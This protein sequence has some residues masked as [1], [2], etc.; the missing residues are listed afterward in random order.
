MKM[1]I[2]RY[3]K[4]MEQLFLRCRKNFISTFYVNVMTLIQSTSDYNVDCVDVSQRINVKLCTIMVNYLAHLL[5]KFHDFTWE[6]GDVNRVQSWRNVAGDCFSLRRRSREY[7]LEKC[8]I[9]FLRCRK[10]WEKDFYGTG[11]IEKVI[12]PVP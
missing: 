7:L 3:R 1:W 8:H 4:N 9:D 11:K 12:F 10:I 5:T 6:N 2:L